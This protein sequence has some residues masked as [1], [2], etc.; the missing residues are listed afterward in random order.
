VR[1]LY[2]AA[3]IRTQTYPETGEWLLV[4]GR[5]I[6]RVGSDEPPLADRVVDLPGATIVPGFIDTHVHLTD[7]GLALANTDVE[8]ARSAADLL[9]VAGARATDTP[10]EGPVYLQ[11]YDE[12][13]WEDPRLPTANELD[14]VTDR[15]LVIRRIDGHISLANTVAIEHAKEPAEEPR[16][17]SGSRGVEQSEDGS[18]TGVLKEEANDA[19]GRWALESLSEHEIQDLQ[20]QAAGLGASR[21][22]TAV[23]EMVMPHWHGD[24]ELLVLLHQRSRLPVDVTPIVATMDLSVA[25][26]H[27]LPAVGGDLPIDGSIGAR[28]AALQAPY[29]GSDD[30]GTTSYSDDE[31]AEFFHGGHT[32]GLQV[33]VHAIGDRAIEQVLGTWERVY[34]ALDSRERRHFRARRHRIEHVEMISAP[35]IE[36]AAVL[37]LA[38]SVQPAFDRLWGGETGLYEQGVGA[39]RAE[40]MNPFRTMLDRGVEVGVGSDAPV[41]SLDPMLCI[42]SLEAHHSPAQRMSRTEA[43]R[44][45]TIGSARVG[46]QEEKKGALA[47][48][49]HADFAAF[50]P[51]PFT[52]HRIE[53]LRPIL[54]VSL[55]R[56]VFAG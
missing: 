42:S 2:R 11:G 10:G 35:Q 54:T 52:A 33:G 1:T 51:D 18:P 9:T 13:R 28:T 37:G 5:H 39:H 15:A 4:D 20:L 47:S 55:G 23:H 32:A 3:R 56:E 40:T 34:H 26:Q 29:E 46:H 45:H 43:I 19:V 16:G 8:A 41:T 14:A 30:T 17:A 25:I 7:T 50:D 24:R 21:G 27:G 12:S 49:M 22:I 48:G 38:A 53:E 6:Q 31:L 44:L 36:R